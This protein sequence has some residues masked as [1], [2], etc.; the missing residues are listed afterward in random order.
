[1]ARTAI[2]VS[3]MVPSLS[4]DDTKLMFGFRSKPMSKSMVGVIDFG[5]KY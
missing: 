5:E 2:T 1:M 3:F 4:F